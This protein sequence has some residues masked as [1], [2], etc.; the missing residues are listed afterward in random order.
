MGSNISPSVINLNVH[1]GV[2][3]SALSNKW[4]YSR[5]ADLASDVNLINPSNVRKGIRG[6][7]GD[8]AS[9]QTSQMFTA[10]NR[11]SSLQ[12]STWSNQVTDTR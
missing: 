6:Y 5:R 4:I 9:V 2:R 11:N 1:H 3:V 12:L 10:T 8:T 7:W